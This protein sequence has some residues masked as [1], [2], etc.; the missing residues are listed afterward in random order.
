MS[1]QEDGGFEEEGPKTT[2]A[3]GNVKVTKKL[4][5][6]TGNRVVPMPLP[7]KAQTTGIKNMFDS[8]GEINGG[9]EINHQRDLMIKMFQDM[10]AKHSQPGSKPMDPQTMQQMSSFMQMMETMNHTP[11]PIASS[12]PRGPI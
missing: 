1:S 5:V 6:K 7:E 12:T 11:Q 2:D 8:S 10:L 9:S 3:K 4:F